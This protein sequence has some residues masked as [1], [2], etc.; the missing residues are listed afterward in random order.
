MN[1]FLYSH[2]TNEFVQEYLVS[3]LFRFHLSVVTLN[4]NYDNYQKKPKSNFNYIKATSETYLY[5]PTHR[6]HLFIHEYL[7][8]KAFPLR[9]KSTLLWFSKH[10]KALILIC[11]VQEDEYH[12]RPLSRAFTLK[13]RYQSYCFVIKRAYMFQI[14]ND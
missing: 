14:I 3:N 4:I 12:H 10:T 9:V 11:L 2:S 6:H 8:I 5:R 13:G 1:S 7:L